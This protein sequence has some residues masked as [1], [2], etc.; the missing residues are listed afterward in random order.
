MVKIY[1]LREMGRKRGFLPNVYFGEGLET[2]YK[3]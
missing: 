2:E 3:Y 1:Y